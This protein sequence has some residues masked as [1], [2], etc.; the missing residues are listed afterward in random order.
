M[1]KCFLTVVMILLSI[2]TLLSNDLIRLIKE[3][4]ISKLKEIVAE[5]P[6][7]LYWK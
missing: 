6:D 5:K 3:G 7:V 1:R 2:F 4:N